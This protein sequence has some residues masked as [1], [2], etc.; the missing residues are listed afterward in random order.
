MVHG[1]RRINTPLPL[2]FSTRRFIH[3]KMSTDQVNSPRDGDGA[4]GT[5]VLHFNQLSAKMN[6]PA[7]S[8]DA[9][10]VIGEGEEQA[11]E[12]HEVIELQTFSERKAWIEEKIKVIQHSSSPLRDAHL[13]IVP[14]AH[15]PH[16]GFR[17]TGCDPCLR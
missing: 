9:G 8:K 10:K 16:R 7:A 3:Q 1:Y 13:Q 4:S 5:T 6:G 12:S 14:R 11:L 15:A 2:A 17:R